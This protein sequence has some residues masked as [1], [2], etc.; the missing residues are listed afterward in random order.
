MNQMKGVACIII[1]D[2]NQVFSTKNI[3]ENSLALA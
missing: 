2:A 3:H 1:D